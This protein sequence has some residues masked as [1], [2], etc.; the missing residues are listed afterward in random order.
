MESQSASL[1]TATEMSFR[2]SAARA[3][4]QVPLEAQRLLLGREFDHDR[5]GP[6][7][8]FDGVA[9]RTVVVPLQPIVD[10]ARQADVM[11]LR[12]AVATE[13]IDEPLADSAHAGAKAILGP[14]SCGTIRSVNVGLRHALSSR[15]RRFCNASVRAT[16]RRLP[17]LGLA[18]VDERCREGF[19]SGGGPP[20]LA[21]RAS[22][23]QPSRVRVFADA[24]QE[25]N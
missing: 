1:L 14:I 18:R 24:R 5:Q 7:A 2:E 21:T 17:S 16:L 10:V 15:V 20:S 13:Y 3:G 8:V 11:T 25:R 22:A 4:L 12:V 6:R 19:E 9:A 23:R